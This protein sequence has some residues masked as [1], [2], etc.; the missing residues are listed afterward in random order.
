MWRK[1]SNPWQG[2]SSYVNKV[3]VL[4][5]N[6]EHI[7]LVMYGPP[8]GPYELRVAPE[9]GNWDWL[10]PNV[11]NRESRSESGIVSNS[12]SNRLALRST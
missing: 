8:G 2:H 10:V 11:T 1:P 12:I 5:G 6:A 4:L 3:F 7:I 9:F